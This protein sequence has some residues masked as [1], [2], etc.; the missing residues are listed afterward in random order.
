M[1]QTHTPSMNPKKLNS[2]QLFTALRHSPEPPK[3]SSERLSS[4]VFALNPIRLIFK[5]EKGT[6]VVPICNIA[7]TVSTYQ[8]AENSRPRGIIHQT[9]LLM[10]TDLGVV[11]VAVD[12]NILLKTANQKRTAQHWQYHVGARTQAGVYWHDLKPMEILPSFS[13]KVPERCHYEQLFSSYT[14]SGFSPF[15][16]F[17]KVMVSHFWQEKD[18]S[19][20]VYFQSC[21]G[22]PAFAVNSYSS[23]SYLVKAA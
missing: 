16:I 15:E 12:H 23:S 5:N 3:F 17:A 18:V 9:V 11:Q 2:L 8:R 13:S 21:V 22:E 6:K 7:A 1:N 4:E 19:Y 20:D 10:H 14:S